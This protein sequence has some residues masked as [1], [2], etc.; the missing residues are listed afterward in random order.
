MG[1]TSKKSRR[2]AALSLPVALLGQCGPSSCEE[3]GPPPGDGFT[4]EL[5]RLCTYEDWV[6][7]TRVTAIETQMAVDAS[8][9]DKVE[10][11]RYRWRLVPSWYLGPLQDAAIEW[12]RTYDVEERYGE[13]IEAG[14]SENWT[15]PINDQE[16]GWHGQ[17]GDSIDTEW[18]L[19]VEYTFVQENWGPNINDDKKIFYASPGTILD[20]EQIA[21]GVEVAPDSGCN[22]VEDTDIGY[23]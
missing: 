22:L 12:S 15:L 6:G 13:Q 9:N 2:V 4:R 18:Y 10:N 17:F 7:S 20:A 3:P 8:V 16:Q 11:F 5:T 1:M 19:Q 14:T 23:S 21:A